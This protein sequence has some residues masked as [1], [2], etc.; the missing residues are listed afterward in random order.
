M[1]RQRGRLTASRARARAS[2]PHPHQ[3]TGLCECWSRYGLVASASRFTGST[4]PDGLRPP[5]TKLPPELDQRG[6]AESDPECERK[7]IDR[8]VAERPPAEIAQHDGVGRPEDRGER[9]ERRGPPPPRKPP[10][11]RGER[12]R[13]PSAGDEARQ[14]QDVA[15]AVVE[16]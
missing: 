8:L 15:P 10:E 16:E 4:L 7:C 9:D 13:N 11:P 1:L 12:G 5:R 6:D 3:S 14:H 2:A